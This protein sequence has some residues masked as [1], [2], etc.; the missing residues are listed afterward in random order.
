MTQLTAEDAVAYRVKKVEGHK[1]NL[2]FESDTVAL[3][4]KSGIFIP[5][6][7]F[8]RKLFMIS[9]RDPR[10]KAYAKSLHKLTSEEKRH[11]E[12]YFFMIHPFSD[13]NFVWQSIMTI[14]HFIVY[15]FIPI[16]YLNHADEAHSPYNTVISSV[17]SSLCLLNIAIS[18]FIGFHDRIENKVIL[19]PKKVFIRYLFTHFPFDVAS[20]LNFNLIGHFTGLFEP[21]WFSR[22]QWMLKLN[23]LFT[24]IQY[25]DNVQSRLNIPNYMLRILKYNMYGGVLLLWLNFSMYSLDLYY[26]RPVDLLDMWNKFFI[27]ANKSCRA[28]FQCGIFKEYYDI[29]HHSDLYLAI[30]AIHCGKFFEIWL[31]AQFFQVFASYMIVT[32]KYQTLLYQVEAFTRFKDLPKRIC[33]RIYSY[34]NFRCQCSI[35]NEKVFT[36]NLCVT[37]KDEIVWNKCQNL[38][39]KVQTFAQLPSP[40]M[41]KLSTMLKPEIYLPNDV[42]I[43]TGEVGNEM[44]FVYVGVLA[45]FTES[46][47]EICHL[48]DGSHFGEIALLLNETRIASVVAI[49]FCE[50]YRL[51]KKDFQEAI[52][53]YPSV[54]EAILKA[55]QDRWRETKIITQ[56]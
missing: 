2:N 41:M 45:V 35:F 6:R 22:F 40:I 3:Y 15:F 31:L 30:A 36:D 27:V 8:Y 14:V 50:L 21:N 49:D 23:R 29:I 5:L 28:I 37:L 46:G 32:R 13:F 24:I 47:K 44:F 17:L 19:R 4:V 48:S 33:R 9:T 20:S 18:F 7:R 56:R 54:K 42:V 55:A 12:R 38:V 1:C 26:N 51:T 34:L 16:Y 53:P 10:T 52:E 39:T 11:L 25:M 43:H